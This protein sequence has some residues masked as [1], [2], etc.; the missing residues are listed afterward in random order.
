MKKIFAYC[1]Q[2]LARLCGLD[3]AEQYERAKEEAATRVAAD[4]P[5]RR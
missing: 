1:T 2:W 4:Q 5:F 3:V